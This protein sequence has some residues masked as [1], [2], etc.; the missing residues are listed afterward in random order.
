MNFAMQIREAFSNLLSAKLRSFLAILGILVGTG[1]VVAMVSSGQ[2]ATQHALEQFKQLGTD[3]L[4]LS[5]Y[6]ETST[7]ESGGTPIPEKLSV[8]DVFKLQQEVKGI[9]AIAPYTTLYS[10]LQFEGIKLDGGIIGATHSLKDVININMSLGRFITSY[11]QFSGF[12][13]I[14]YNLAN[15]LKQQG[16]TN[17]LNM[18]IR[19]GPNIFTIVGVADKWLENSFF[20]QDINRSVLVPIEVSNV[21]SSYTNINNIVMRLEPDVDIQKLQADITLF[22]NQKYPGMKLFFRSAQ[23][24]ITSMTSQK[25]TLTLLLALIGSI[26]LVVGGI[27]VMNIMLVS[28]VERKRE[29]GIRKAVGAKRSDIQILFLVEAV[30]L[31]LFGGLMG[32]IF[33]VLTS[34]IIAL[35]AGWT[36]S[37]FL[38]PPFIGFIVS[39]AIGVFFGF[40]PAYQA[41]RLDPIKTLRSD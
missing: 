25:Q 39:V 16:I 2:L 20:N 31:A 21:L 41:S 3:L 36:F 15:D 40:Y 14:G 35:F 11:D 22:F 28:V 19:L 24:L 23:Q 6:E 34:F 12:C 5:L 27:G 33:G 10:D 8:S 4:S 29:I 9:R 17:P 18:Q 30:A 38:L 32:V 26:S 7:D 37:L 13:V 1:S